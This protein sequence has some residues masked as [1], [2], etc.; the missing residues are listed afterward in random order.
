MGKQKSSKW[1]LE[2]KRLK[3]INQDGLRCFENSEDATKLGTSILESFWEAI[4]DTN[5]SPNEIGEVYDIYFRH[6]VHV[7]DKNGI[8]LTRS[9]EELK[10]T[11]IGQR[12]LPG[13]VAHT[14]ARKRVL[15]RASEPAVVA[16][17]V[18]DDFVWIGERIVQEKNKPDVRQDRQYMIEFAKPSTYTDGW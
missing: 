13:S 5:C 7:Q 15:F 2:E 12:N 4:L 3:K 11:E 1:K 17:Q 6:N 14:C 18:F 9:L 8:V 10:Q 16:A